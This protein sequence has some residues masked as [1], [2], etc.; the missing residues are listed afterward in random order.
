MKKTI[1]A[2]CSFLLLFGGAN[3]Q[4]AKATTGSTSVNT[5]G[6]HPKLTVE[7]RAKRRAEKYTTICAISADQYNTILKINTTFFTQKDQ[8]VKSDQSKEAI[9]A[10]AKERNQQERKVL[11]SEQLAKWKAYQQQKKGQAQTGTKAKEVAPKGT[12]QE[13]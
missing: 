11:T 7:E 6:N 4:Q 8:V 13:D 12:G 3:A 5:R 2:L 1:I 10:L 9:H